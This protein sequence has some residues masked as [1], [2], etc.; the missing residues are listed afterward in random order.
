M[1]THILARFSVI[2]LVATVLALGAGATTASA[3]TPGCDDIID[4]TNQALAPGLCQTLN[5]GNACYAS[6]NV[7]ATLS[8]PTT[9]DEPGDQV[10]LTNVRRVNA[11]EPEGSAFLLAGTPGN[12]VKVFVFGGAR[13]DPSTGQAARVFTLRSI[14]GQPACERT[15]SGMILQAPPGQTST[16]IVNGVTIRLGSTAYIVPGA[17]LLFDQDPRKDRRRGSRNPDAPLC[18]GFDSDCGFGDESCSFDERMVWGPFCRPDAYPYIRNGLYRVTLYGNGRVLAGAT[19]YEAGGRDQFSIMEEEFNL[20]GSYTFCWRWREGGSGFETVIKSRRSGTAVDHITL[21]YLGRDCG[22]SLPSSRSAVQPMDMM[23]VYNVEGEV[24][25][26][27]QGIVRTPGELERI[28]IYYD[29]NV[30]RAMDPAPLDATYVIDSPLVQWA[31][32]GDDGEGGLPDVNPGDEDFPPSF[33]EP[34]P[35]P[36]PEPSA[37]TARLAIEPI[38]DGYTLGVSVEVV[39]YDPDEGR[40]NGDGIDRVYFA[41]VGPDNYIV[42]E[43][44]ESIAAYCAFSGNESPCPPYYFGSN[45]MEWPF[46]A[47]VEDGR[48]RVFATV[49]TK[50][51]VET[52]L[53]GTFDVRL[54]P[55]DVEG[56]II[57][58]VATDPEGNVCYGWDLFIEAAI[59]DESGVRSA[60]LRY[61]T[62]SDDV[63]IP[64][65]RSRTMTSR[66][67]VY[68]SQISDISS[69]DIDFY[70]EAVDFNGNRTRSEVFNRRGV[71]CID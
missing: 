6:D 19:D 49:F 35:E 68:V 45:D 23:T 3:Q 59:E 61:R 40:D 32:Y 24:Q 71:R 50:R 58:Y 67:N 11:L 66:G 62:Y 22:L 4:N 33:P 34:E 65:F 56:P 12:P 63:G 20:P 57:E 38:F 48:Y 55:Q 31:T 60:T 9:F 8:I 43:T 26:S 10:A 39:A 53:E 21:E 17:D 18:S 16:I 52:T 5:L 44:T 70:I 1:W 30:P 46:G 2:L 54:A 37:P 51:G 41:I 25:V 36:E 28:R 69:T 7:S 64:G 14:N 15:R 13:L 29:G 27:A 42:Q 47:R